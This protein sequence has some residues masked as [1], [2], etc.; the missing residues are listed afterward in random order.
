MLSGGE[1]RVGTGTGIQAARNETLQN[2]VSVVKLPFFLHTLFEGK[3]SLL[4]RR[5]V[6]FWRPVAHGVPRRAPATESVR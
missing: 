1:Q 4:E 5:K 2:R 6:S 3:P